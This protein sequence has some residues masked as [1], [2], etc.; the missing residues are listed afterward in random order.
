MNL[1]RQEQW[2]GL[3]GVVSEAFS[4]GRSNAET[5]Q[6]LLDAGVRI[7][8]YREK[9]KSDCERLEEC[10]AL[11]RMTSSAGALF[12]V[13]DRPDLALLVGADAVH[14][15]QDDLPIEA[16]RYLVGSSMAV[17]VSTHGP[18][19]AQE[20]WKAGADYIG[21]GPVF[22][23]STKEQAGSAVGLDYVRYVVE[24]IPVPAVCIGGINEK[25]IGQ[26]AD[27]GAQCICVI[28]DLIGA[29]DIRSKA[30]ALQAALG[31][32]QS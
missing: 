23:T 16:V 7:I 4:C 29:A 19:Q 24:E 6:S 27:A 25:N 30:D 17:G 1:S 32:V 20:A 9:H 21:A 8:Q 2:Q 13:N 14:I 22:T 3:Y 11:R 18:Q 28:S 10:R 26:V 12:V 5:A 31:S 15:G